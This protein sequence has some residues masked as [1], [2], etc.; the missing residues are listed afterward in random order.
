MT[1]QQL[2]ALLRKAAEQE[3]EANE[4]REKLE[5]LGKVPIKVKKDW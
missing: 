4:K 3:R 2:E 1:Q 5:A